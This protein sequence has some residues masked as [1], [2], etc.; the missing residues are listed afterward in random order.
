MRDAL[1]RMHALGEV[2]EAP[3]FRMWV[4]EAQLDLQMRVDD[5][6]EIT[7]QVEAWSETPSE[8][9]YAV[10]PSYLLDVTS[11]WPTANLDVEYCPDNNLRPFCA[12][13][14][15]LMIMWMPFRDPTP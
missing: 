2:D 13:Q 7:D 8:L 11:V 15:G 1:L 14:N 10:T 5:V 9:R 3:R 4:R 6:G 12:E